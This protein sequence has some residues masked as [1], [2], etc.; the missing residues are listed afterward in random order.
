MRDREKLVLMTPFK[1][2]NAVI[3]EPR[4][5]RGFSG[6]QENQFLY[7]L[8]YLIQIPNPMFLPLGHT[9]LSIREEKNLQ[10]EIKFNILT[11]TY[12]T[13][14]D[15]FSSLL[16]KVITEIILAGVV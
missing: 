1:Y 6:T 12:I 15:I 13:L 9:I 4:E 16:I 10:I 3:P 8:L 14:F 5:P 2:L 7:F 11:I